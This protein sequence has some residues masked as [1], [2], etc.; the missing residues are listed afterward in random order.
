MIKQSD[1]DIKL[2]IQFTQKILAL[3][4][5]KQMKIYKKNRA[6]EVDL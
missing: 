6:L 3:K 2:L 4:E 5:I 1:M